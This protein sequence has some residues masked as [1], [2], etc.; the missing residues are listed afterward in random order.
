MFNYIDILDVNTVQNQIS[1]PQYHEK[2]YE[3]PKFK[4]T[5]KLLKLESSHALSQYESVRHMRSV[6]LDKL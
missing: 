6:K 3:F 4:L 1:M 2:S 5:E